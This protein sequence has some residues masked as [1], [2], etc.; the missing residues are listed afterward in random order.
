MVSSYGEAALE[1]KVKIHG[2]FHT[3]QAIAI[4]RPPL[5][6]R[7][8]S[9]GQR[10]KLK[11]ASVLEQAYLVLRDTWCTVSITVLENRRAS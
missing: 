6:T 1:H 7:G 5:C 11:A 9:Q 4:R 2:C 8:E 10:E 3:T